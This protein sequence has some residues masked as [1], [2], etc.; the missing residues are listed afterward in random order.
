M[1]LR[2]PVYTEKAEC[3]DCYKCVRHCPV[4]AIRVENGSAMVIAEQC[5]ACGR[6]VAVCPAGA[7][8]V[9]DDLE[10]VK[11]LLAGGGRVVV[12]LAPSHVSEFSDVPP[13]VLVGALKQLGFYGVSE[14][15]LGA[16][17]V[18]A[19]VAAR[20]ALPAPGVL[21]SSACP[22][23]VELV[24]KHFPQHADRV[25]AL[26]SPLLAHCRLLKRELGEDVTV[27]FIGPCVAKKMEADAHPE[28][29]AA[30]IT[31]EDLRAWFKEAKIELVATGA[32]TAECAFIPCR[33]EEGALY[34]VD[35]GMAAGIKA[36]CGCVDATFMAFS[37][38]EN[39]RDALE[40]L[41]AEAAPGKPMFL[42]LLACA[43]GC[44]NGPCAKTQTGTALKRRRILE[45]APKPTVS[46]P[47]QGS[48]DVVLALPAPV[49]PP[50]VRNEAE[51]AD[52]L[53]TVG[54]YRKEDELNCGGCGYG[55]C[56][57]FA[58]ALLAGKAEKTMC[59]SHM[60]KLAQRKANALIRAMPSGVVI[61]DQALKVV[62][63]NRRFATLLGEDT[64]AAYQVRPGL[65]GALLAKTAPFLTP[66]VEHVLRGGPDVLFHTAHHGGNI[67]QFSV[68]T[69]EA[70]RV[71]G[72][73]LRDVT[74]PS[75]QK[76]QVIR[77]ARNVIRKNLATVQKIAYLLGENAAESQ[78]TLS[79]IIES[80]EAEPTVP[81]AKRE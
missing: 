22:T 52:A 38:M 41:E 64:L 73:V 13:A 18:S 27:V 57:E 79:A 24:R 59:V 19:A 54:K 3:Q 36:G 12:S 68:F 48:L 16:Q 17:E 78:A 77:Q 15:A 6:C 4:K 65:E 61:V 28:L 70:G 81:Q 14:T 56:R 40:G 62:E 55:G 45:H 66:F 49:N 50:P 26:C 25:T 76:E 21:V 5:V 51:I 20:L 35:G 53:E 74:E 69:V 63:C 11:A 30:A 47:R 9:R 33:A 71:A 44:V 60:R 29:L 80:F 37:G 2:H 8:R 67:W 23:V 10:R 32:E 42:E 1:N 72:A 75:V 39:L 7:K 34:P 31:F 43:G 46:V 58:G